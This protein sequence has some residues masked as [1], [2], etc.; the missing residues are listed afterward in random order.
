MILAGV[1]AIMQLGIVTGLLTN[2][3]AAMIQPLAIETFLEMVT[4]LTDSDLIVLTFTNSD[5]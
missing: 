1:P 3:P 5:G 4:F 2:A